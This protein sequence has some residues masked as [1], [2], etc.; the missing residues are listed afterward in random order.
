MIKLL[1]LQFACLVIREGCPQSADTTM[2]PLFNEENHEG[3]KFEL[4]L[5]PGL[6]Q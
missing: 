3:T 1:L 4:Q 6:R 5:F 2:A